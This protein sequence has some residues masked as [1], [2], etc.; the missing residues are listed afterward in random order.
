MYENAN[1]S[2]KSWLPLVALTV[3]TYIV[4]TDASLADKVEAIGEPLPSGTEPS[5]I[6]AELPISEPSEMQ[7]LALPGA[8]V[9]ETLS[10]A[11]LEKEDV[12][13]RGAAEKERLQEGSAKCG[14]CYRG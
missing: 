1:F 4:F 5:S 2:T 9:A 11:S 6:P 13:T 7:R 14:C 12:L 8:R 10:Q 3:V